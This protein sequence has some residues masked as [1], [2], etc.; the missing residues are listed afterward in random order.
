MGEQTCGICFSLID[1]TNV[2]GFINSCDHIFCS[3]C[4]TEWGASCN[5]CPQCKRRFTRIQSV[6]P[7][8]GEQKVK[9]IRLRNLHV[10]DSDDSDE[11]GDGESGTSAS[12]AAE[13]SLVCTV[14]GHGG[15]LPSMI[16]CDRRGCS[17]CAHLQCLGLTEHP[18]TY[19][20]AACSGLAASPASPGP[21]PAPM[22]SAQRAQPAAREVASAAAV[23]PSPP[24]Q[25]QAP[26]QGEED[27]DVTLDFEEQAA[28]DAYN[29]TMA[30]G[31]SADAFL[32]EDIEHD[33]LVSTKV[34]FP[35][36]S[37]D[38]M[39][40][41]ADTAEYMLRQRARCVEELQRRKENRKRRNVQPAGGGKRPRER[42]NAPLQPLAD[43]EKAVFARQF[44]QELANARACPF[45]TTHAPPVAFR[46]NEF[47]VPIVSA[48]KSLSMSS[49]RLP[50]EP[51]DPRLEAAARSAARRYT[52]DYMAQ[53]KTLRQQHLARAAE[54]ASKREEAALRQL[55]SLIK[56][57]RDELLLR[58]ELA[59]VEPKAEELTPRH[60]PKTEQ[61]T[62]RHNE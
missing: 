62:P 54:R 5:M 42:R 48:P 27:E 23:R 19:V 37:S 24:V 32:H 43:V 33:P 22:Q 4:I 28:A 31:E 57:K 26:Q 20:C 38:L 11:E 51:L 15:N 46:V 7:Q 60:E 6:D 34:P 12:T 58:G 47:G 2:R 59:K 40:N 1:Q 16:I 18:D 50:E 30:V 21:P 39:T 9:K 56:A 41:S 35:S 44:A 13:R 61:V 49:P 17:F 55:R 8:T 53:V 25:Q 36:P 14:C 10:D 3:F 29:A 52:D 45:L